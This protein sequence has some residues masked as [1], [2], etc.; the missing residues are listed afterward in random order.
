MRRHPAGEAHYD[1]NH[2]H[3]IGQI[4]GPLTYG[5]MA[6]AIEVRGWLSSMDERTPGDSYFHVTAT[7]GGKLKSLAIDTSRRRPPEDGLRLVSHD[8]GTD[9]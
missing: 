3:M 9:E 4:C 8:G 1:G 2:E 5:G 6:V 7:W